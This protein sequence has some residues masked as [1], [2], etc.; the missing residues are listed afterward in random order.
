[1][2]RLFIKHFGNQLFILNSKNVKEKYSP[3][4]LQYKVLLKTNSNYS[5]D[6]QINQKKG[7]F[8]DDLLNK[9]TSL[10]KENL[11]FEKQPQ[12]N[13]KSLQSHFGVVSQSHSKISSYL[14]LDRQINEFRRFNE[15]NLSRVYPSVFKMD[16]SNFN[17]IAYWKAG[18]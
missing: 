8:Q 3:L 16:S 17:P 9:I 18:F 6:L 15:Q 4:D 12:R 1:M 5:S 10:F 14:K 2:A 13:L 11:T 7:D